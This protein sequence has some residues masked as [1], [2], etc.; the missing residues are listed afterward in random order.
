MNFLLDTN[1]VSEWIKP[2]PDEGVAAWLAEVDEDRT[3][4]SVATLAELHHGIEIMPLGAKRNRLD[5]WLCEELLPRFE[6]RLLPISPAIAEVWGK[7][8][9]RSQA[10][11][12]T[13]GIM[14]TFLAATAEVHG[15]TVVTRNVK[16]FSVL[17]YP[18]FNPW[19]A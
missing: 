16:H 1:V 13:M 11:G 12:R 14:D 9:A 19:T 3:F 7:V 4:L 2:Y 10:V 5:L 17:E 8:A 6:T 15:L 18:A